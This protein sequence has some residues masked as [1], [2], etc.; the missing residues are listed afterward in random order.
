MKICLLICWFGEFPKYLPIWLKTCNHNRKFD[1]LLLSDVETQFQMP[2]NVKFIPFTR[3]KFLRRVKERIV[4]N[5]SFDKSYRVCDFRPMYGIIFREEL[6]SYDFWGYCDV[7]VVFGNISRFIDEND[8]NEKEAI[9]NG[10]HFTLIKNCEKMNTLYKSKGAV[11]DFKTVTMKDAIYAFDETTGIQR[12]AHVQKINSIWGIPYIDIESK[13]T[14][15]RSRMDKCN[16]E[17]QAFYWENGNLYRVKEENENLYYQEIMYL[18]LQKRKI[19]ILD[20]EVIEGDSFWIT[21]DGFT[22]KKRSGLPNKEEIRE[23]NPDMGQDIRQREEN[24]YRKS[25]LIEIFKR[26][27]FQIYVRV[28]QQ[29][30]G[31]NARDRAGEE[32][33][34]IKY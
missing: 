10:G 29:I 19:S 18:H 21:P 7:D 27:P 11:F 2:D 3:E 12:I 31:I 15:L 28:C 23:S 20:S 13:Y 17:N 4:A 8:F 25:K 34:W 22:K 6:E 5:P 30:A 16:P 24:A 32:F 26:S 33:E 9:F 14:Q 1:F